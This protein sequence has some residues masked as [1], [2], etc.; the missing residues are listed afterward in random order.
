M[1]PFRE[2]ICSD[3]GSGGLGLKTA[4]VMNK[5]LQMKLIWKLKTEPSNI[6]V[7]LIEEKY[8]KGE[9]ILRIQKK[10]KHFLAIC[11][12]TQYHRLF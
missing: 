7:K 10:N 6:W 4:E 8:L 2:N 12:A 3:I 1:N 11:K 5:T 9:D